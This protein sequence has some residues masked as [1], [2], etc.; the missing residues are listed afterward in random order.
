MLTGS[1][2]AARED[3]ALRPHRFRIAWVDPGTGRRAG[4]ASQWIELPGWVSVVPAHGRAFTVT[5]S[6]VDGRLHLEWQATGWYSG[7]ARPTPEMAD[8][9]RRFA[10]GVVIVD[11]QGGAAES[12][13]EATD[14]SGK[15]ALA[16]GSA[17]RT[18][19]GVQPWTVGDRKYQVRREEAN[20]RQE[21]F[22]E[23]RGPTAADHV[24]RWLLGALNDQVVAAPDH[25]AL[26]VFHAGRT[27]KPTCALWRI[28]V[29]G[30]LLEFACESAP[31]SGTWMGN[32]AYL[33]IRVS[34]GGGVSHRLR[35]VSIASG[36]VAFER[37][38]H[39]PS[40]LRH[41]R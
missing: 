14:L 34:D 38:I 25:R 39:S 37:R 30:R 19:T 12:V 8:S 35:A 1:R 26:V 18:A 15:A 41:P 23:R 5:P 6:L 33:L 28:D 17:A 24:D 31:I 40:G 32:L 21:I 2:L 4:P 22:L 10:R 20:G 11:P 3:D 36:S 16:A 9:E 13:G 27:G 29:P 7:G